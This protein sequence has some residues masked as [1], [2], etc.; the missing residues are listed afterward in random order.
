MRTL[1]HYLQELFPG[2]KP[3]SERMAAVTDSHAVHE[4]GYDVCY[5]RYSLTYRDR[6]RE[7][8]LGAEFDDEGVLAVHSADC[9]RD[10]AVRIAAALEFLG[11]KHVID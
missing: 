9:P 4:S 3:G 11:V 7:L 2:G 5:S 8:S 6:G 10:V 1:Q